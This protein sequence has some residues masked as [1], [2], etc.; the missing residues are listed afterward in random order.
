[1]TYG[2]SI[3]SYKTPKESFGKL[4]LVNSKKKM[5]DSQ[6]GVFVFEELESMNGV[7]MDSLISLVSSQENRFRTTKRQFY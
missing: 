6:R 5:P 4:C 2:S 7:T 1:M 3:Y